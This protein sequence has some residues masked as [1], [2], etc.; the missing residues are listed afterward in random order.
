MGCYG[1]SD[2][3]PKPYR[4]HMRDPSFVNLQALRPLAKGGYL[5]DLIAVIAS[6][7]PVMGGVDR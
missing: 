7:D 2:G 4:V 1:V 5:A 3:G 6:L